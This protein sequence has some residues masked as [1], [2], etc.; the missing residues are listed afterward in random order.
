MC[1]GSSHGDFALFGGLCGCQ[2]DLVPH[3]K[4][5]SDR[6]LGG[7]WVRRRNAIRIRSFRYFIVP[8]VEGWWQFCFANILAVNPRL[9]HCDCKREIVQRILCQRDKAE[10]NAEKNYILYPSHIR[11][12]RSGKG[13]RH[14]HQLLC[15]H[16]VWV[17]EGQAMRSDQYWWADH[18]A[19][20]GWS[21]L[22]SGSGRWCGNCNRSNGAICACFCAID[23]LP[24]RGKRV[25]LR[26]Y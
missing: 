15:L 18:N 21:I 1:R 16:G 20:N 23:R 13:A 6:R 14:L 2:A 19:F 12:L 26:R 10:L 9:R 24:L 4:M 22:S 7:C 5:G 25:M 3:H 8:N 11:C 17:S